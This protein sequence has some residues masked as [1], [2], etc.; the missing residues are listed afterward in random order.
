[1]TLTTID[2]FAGAARQKVLLNKVAGRS[3]VATG[4]YSVFDLAGNPGPG[5]LAGTSTVA[6]VVP[7]DLTAGAP[8]GFRL[9]GGAVGYLT[10]VEFSNSF[11]CRM[12]VH[13]LLFKAGAYAFGAGTTTLSGQ[14]SFSARVPG[15]VFNACEIWIEVSTA[16][17]TGTA[18]Q[19]QVTY[20]NQSG[21]TGRSTTITPAL[22]A[23]ALTQGRMY[24]L[25]LQAGDSGV[26]RIDSVIV[27]NGGTAMT[28]GAFNV[29]VMREL[30]ANRVQSANGGGAQ[31]L[32]DLDRPEVFADSALF[33][34]IAADGTNTGIPDV[35]MTISNG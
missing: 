2:E 3:A 24:Q 13:D 10:N 17:A 14:P 12:Q 34:S 35:R 31:G 27:T 18:W 23:A 9:G 20:T 25:G 16:F 32:V 21:V 19:V 7:P 29:L 5:V 22:N 1:M 28:A 4:W 8:P 30:W 26:Q 11:A 15:G 6:G 33:L